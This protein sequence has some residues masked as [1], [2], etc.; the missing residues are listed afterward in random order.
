MHSHYAPELGRFVEHE[1]L[2]SGAH[3]HAE[4]RRADGSAVSVVVRGPGNYSPHGMPESRRSE[5]TN[6]DQG[7]RTA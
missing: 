1:H 2:H 7:G 6:D 4:V 3:R 5:A